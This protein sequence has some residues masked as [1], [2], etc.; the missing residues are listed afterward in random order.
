M[1]TRAVFYIA[2][3]ADDGRYLREAALS[4]ASVQEHLP[5]PTILF[6]DIAFASP[7]FDQIHR[8]PPS[9]IEPW[10]LKSA[11]WFNYAISELRDYDQLL[12]LDTDTH[13]CRDCMDMFDLLERFDMAIGHSAS[14]DVNVSIYDTPPAL[15]TP[16]IG[17]NIFRNSQR[18][19]FF[20]ANWLQFYKENA[21]TYGDNDEAPLRDA[22][23]EN[24]QGITWATLPPEYC[25]RFD[26]GCWV[27]GWVRILH[28]RDGG[29]ST[30]RRSLARVADAIN[31][32]F[33]MRQWRHGIIE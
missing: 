33:G 2:T 8:L 22:M 17:V 31:C 13:V 16:Q 27:Y 12:Y 21:V 14:R 30:D 3:A 18:M 20:W 1:T 29:I 5:L 11:G 23:W 10:Y 9:D 24:G 19:R 15:T 26:F 4:A 32:R 6:T 7:H 25:L 28:G